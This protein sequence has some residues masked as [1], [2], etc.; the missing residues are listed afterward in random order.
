LTKSKLEMN[1]HWLQN[2]AY[3]IELSVWMFVFAAGLALVIAL[4]I[5]SFQTVRAALKN[6]VDSLQYE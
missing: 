5:V 1:K 3:R 4:I 2:F 6:P